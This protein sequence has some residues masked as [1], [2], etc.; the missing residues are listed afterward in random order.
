MTTTNL[1]PARFLFTTWE[2]GGNLPPV[3]TV[4]AKLTRLGHAVRVMG[5]RVN[6]E[7]AEAVG[8]EFIPWTRAPNRSDRSRASD[9]FRDWEAT[10]PQDGVLRMF[11]GMM[12]G[13]ALAYAQ[14]VLAE[15]ARAPADLVVSSEM[16]FGVMAACESVGQKLALLTANLSLFPLPGVPPFGP[17]LPIAQTD[18]ERA[19]HA[20]I[21]AGNTDLFDQGRPALNAARQALGLTA[22]Y[23]VFDQVKTADALLLGTSRAFD[24]PAEHLPDYIRYVG[25]QLGEPLWAASWTSP[26]PQTDQ[27]PLVAVA[28]STTFQNHA[29]VL[30]AVSDALS[31]LPVRGLVTLAG[32]DPAEVRA[33]DNVVLVSSAPHDAVMR[34]AAVVITHGGHGTVMRALAHRKPL[35]IIPHGRDQND[36]AVRV[37]ARGAGLVLTPGAG[38]QEIASAVRRLLDDD[39]FSQAAVRLGTAVAE[40]AAHSRVVAEL[41]SLAAKTAS[42][43]SLLQFAWA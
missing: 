23:H 7:A 12:F 36:N 3:L 43:S 21:A 33:S 10:S 20:Q 35:L 31:T 28:F 15:L 16:L 27:R 40:E 24:F 6:R 37:S 5:D 32:I 1:T 26:W 25:P 18:A 29:G 4:V 2:G 30:Q 14:D 13:P 8:A 39:S 22:L 42:R 19:L 17:G 41:E 38:P 9:L 11:D 34:E